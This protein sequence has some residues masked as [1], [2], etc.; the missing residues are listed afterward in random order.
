MK[1]LLFLF[2]L[3]PMIGIAQPGK[4]RYESP[5]VN[6]IEL[7]GINE[8]NTELQLLG[9][10][11]IFNPRAS[12]F[13][14]TV[15]EHKTLLDSTC[16]F[17][18]RSAIDSSLTSRTINKYDANGNLVLQSFNY[19]RSPPPGESYKNEYILDENGNCKIRRYFTWD[20]EAKQWI[21][22]D[23]YENTYDIEG[24]LIKIMSAR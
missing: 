12:A 23:V 3:I 4:M 1:F 10:E 19:L 15:D 8:W 5:E 21:K 13:L 22:R 7:S 6:P 18:F 2:T 11:N 14:N 9:G 20:Y 16:N 17:H 24:R